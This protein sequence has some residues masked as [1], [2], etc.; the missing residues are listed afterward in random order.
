MKCK[1]DGENIEKYVTGLREIALKYLI[2]ENLLS[3]C[4]GQREMMLVLH[5]VMQRYKL[6]Y[7][8]PTIS[9]FFFLLMYLT[10]KKVA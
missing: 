4:K 10:V 2:N 5:T 8:T 6:M 1:C 9:S 3:W 7:S